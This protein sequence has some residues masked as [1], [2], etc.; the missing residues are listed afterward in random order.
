MA[1]SGSSILFYFILVTFSSSGSPRKERHKESSL[2]KFGE[3]LCKA[4]RLILF[5]KERLQK[6]VS[7]TPRTK[8]L[9]RLNMLKNTVYVCKGCICSTLIPPHQLFKFAYMGKFRWPYRFVPTYYYY[10]P[11]FRPNQFYRMDSTSSSTSARPSQAA[12]VE[13]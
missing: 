5:N 3:L 7:K 12:L 11:T 4:L 1:M 13:D 6:N 8:F 2:E 9:W 10:L